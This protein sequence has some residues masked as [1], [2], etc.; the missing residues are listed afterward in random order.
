MPFSKNLLDNDD[1]MP[2]DPVKVIIAGAGLGGICLG[3]LL[4]KAQI[5]YCV[6]EQADRVT[7][8]GSAMAVTGNVFP[9]FEQLG[10]MP[11]ILARSKEVGTLEGYNEKMKLF[12]PMNYTFA[13]QLTGFLPRIITHPD[14]HEILLSRI[15]VHKI[16]WG[17]RVVHVDQTP[18]SLRVHF[19]DGSSFPGQVLVGADGT[20]S[21]VRT[22]IYKTLADKSELPRVDKEPVMFNGVCLV[23]ETKPLN[24]A[25]FPRINDPK[26]NV[27]AVY[28]EKRPY[29]WAITSTWRNTLCWVLIEFFDKSK[30]QEAEYI[31]RW[32]ST[33]AGE[34][35]EAVKDFPI[36][37]GANLTLGD[38][39]AETSR[40]LLSKVMNEEKFFQ[41]WH[42]GRTVLLGDAAHKMSL[43]GGLGAVNAFQDA[44]VLANYLYS[45]PSTDT[46]KQSDVT[47]AFRGYKAERYGSAKHACDMGHSI[48]QLTGKTWSAE[49]TRTFAS[50]T[51]LW[52]LALR[53][54]FANRPQAAFLPLVENTGTLKPLPQPS[55]S[56]TRIDADQWSTT[57]GKEPAVV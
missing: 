2:R 24:A 48:G 39:M 17:K 47:Q 5:P 43:A 28:S 6:F 21:G 54:V 10:L 16:V 1:D 56:L 41:T 50:F 34:M 27:Q 57:S 35:C 29:Y 52:K 30:L 4:E 53:R 31:K 49:V 7:R 42:S 44:V 18:D 45:L 25:Q 46:W 37:G 9:M 13:K 55:L 36:P 38:L 26:S 33:P 15:P 20:H 12:L 51:W 19:T 11:D 40:K 22:S 3:I 8:L 14:L 32:K 23:G